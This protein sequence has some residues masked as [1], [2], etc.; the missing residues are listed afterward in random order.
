MEY[1]NKLK[2]LIK[3]PLLDTY[4]NILLKSNFIN[5]F[6]GYQISTTN[7]LKNKPFLF[8]CFALSIDGK[9]AYIDK[10]SG[11]NIA[12]ANHLA[13][14][15]E[16]FS[17]FTTLMIARAV[18]D[19][20]IFGTNSIHAENG[21][22]LPNLNIKELITDRQQQNKPKQIFTIIICRDLN[23]INFTNPL[24]SS[25]KYPVLI[26]CTN[27]YD[28]KSI[29]NAYNILTLDQL[30]SKIHL[31]IKNILYFPQPITKLMS[32]LKNIGFNVILNESPF[33]HHQFLQYGLLNEMWINYSSSYI[34]GNACTLGSNSK[35]FTS[36]D[37][38]N[39]EMLS[40]HHLDYHFLYSR[41][42]IKNSCNN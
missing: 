29:P 20:V 25:S 34:G 42:L 27:R 33:F 38:P 15:K 39:C 17:D 18:C 3:N 36:Y 31:A 10:P 4:E 30:K 16:K 14:D 11:F 8:S 7:F 22:Y 1:N 12:K 5:N 26:C 37:H 35:A 41:W 13:T 21:V 6:F 9:V 28:L 2:L 23:K 40:L 32:I 19:A 24:F